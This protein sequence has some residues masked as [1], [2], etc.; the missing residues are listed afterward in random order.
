MA[1]PAIHE[2]RDEQVDASLFVETRPSLNPHRLEHV[3]RRLTSVDLRHHS[4]CFHESPQARVLQ[5]RC[6]H[7][8]VAEHLGSKGGRPRQNALDV[9]DG[10]F[11]IAHHPP[12]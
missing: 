7:R 1:T 11:P 8:V 4:G 9:H 5:H 12:D 10:S 6:K 2:R 3:W